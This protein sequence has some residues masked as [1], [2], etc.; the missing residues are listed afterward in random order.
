M[1][2]VDRLIEEHSEL[3]RRYFLRLGAAGLAAAGLARVSAKAAAPAP[4]LAQAL[5]KLAYLTPQADFG[6]VERGKPLPYTLPPK[7]LR[8]VGLVRETWQLEV[9]ADPDSNSKIKTPLSKELGTALDFKGLM[10]LAEKHAVRF[11]K[12]MTC[13]NGGSPLGMGLWE[14]V[15]LREVIWKTG[16][17][18]NIRRVFFHGY[19]NDDPKQMFRGSLPIGRVL[20]EPPG[21]PPVIL[22]YK[23]N[24]DWISGKRGGP[25][26]L[27]APE[28]YGFKSIKW[29]NRVLL[30]NLFHANDTYA[31]GN[32]DVDSWLKTFARFLSHPGRVKPEQPIP[33]TGVAQVGI[34]G[35]SRVQVWITPKTTKLPQDDPYFTKGEWKDVDILPPPKKWGGGLP[36][37]RLEGPTFGFDASSGKPTSWPIRYTIAHWAKLLPGLPEGKYDM[38]CRTI[39]AKGIAQPLP[40][41]FRKSG[42]NK[43]ERVTLIVES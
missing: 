22:C 9:V 23:L 30:T 42:R 31:S 15:P 2:D 4:E 32:N 33:V 37:D 41:P 10:K 18:E 17:V 3:T 43:I 36:N 34:S 1:T 5:A 38:R 16:P 6:T 20:E 7:K 21:M 27:I 13:N 8:E 29:L 24:G 14:G 35:L 39:D 11:M 28:A 12:V 25:V 40:R 26:R 19:H